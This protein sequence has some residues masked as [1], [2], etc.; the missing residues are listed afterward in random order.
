MLSFFSFGYHAWAD[1]FTYYP[2]M[3]L[4]LLMA[5]FLSRQEKGKY[6]WKYVPLVVAAVVYSLWMRLEL[7]HWRDTLRVFTR[8]VEVTPRNAFAN[9]RLGETY[10]RTGDAKRAIE[11]F[12]RSIEAMPNDENLGGLAIAKTFFSVSTDFSEVK[13]LAQK[14][15]AYDP[16]SPAGNE[17]MGF[18]CIR[19]AQWAEAERHLTISI[20][21]RS[22]N[23]LVFEWLAMAQFNQRK[24]REALA[25]IERAIAINPSNQALRERRASIRQLLEKGFGPRR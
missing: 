12:Q 8:A 4:V 21:S 13:M 9:C 7:P 23:P 6:G 16:A 10:I 18:I 25:S 20:K 24:H 1:R 17:A 5:L 19:T 22:D 15:I 3:A 11:A 2:S 14:A